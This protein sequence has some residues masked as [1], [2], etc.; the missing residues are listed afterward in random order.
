MS[1]N[2][3][4]SLVANTA[5]IETAFRVRCENREATPAEHETLSRYSGFGG[6][7]EILDLGTDNPMPDKM[8]TA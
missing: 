2:K 7:K 3:L 6:I 1:Y 5:A 4:Q 8:K